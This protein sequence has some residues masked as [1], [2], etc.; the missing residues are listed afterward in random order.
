MMTLFAQDLLHYFSETRSLPVTERPSDALP[1]NL[2]ID[3]AVTSHPRFV[4]KASA[5]A[6]TPQFQKPATPTNPFPSPTEQ[7]HLIGYD[8][9]TRLLSPKYY[10]P[11]HN[12]SPLN[13]MFTHHRLRVTYRLS[14]SDNKYGDREEQDQYLRDLKEGKREGEGGK[15]EWAERIEMVEGLGNGTS[16]TGVREGIAKGEEE[17]RRVVEGMCSKSVGEWIFRQGLYR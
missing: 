5:I 17:G 4:D 8:T 12:L 3:I 13:E 2:A 6:S 7:Y 1:P 14:P 15:R 9:L 16:S 11:D 10:P